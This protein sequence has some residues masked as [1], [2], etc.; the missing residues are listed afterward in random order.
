MLDARRVQA[1]QSL[2]P[3]V[4]K[5][6]QPAKNGEL[7]EGKNERQKTAHR[8]G[9]ARL[10]VVCCGSCCQYSWHKKWHIYRKTSRWAISIYTEVLCRCWISGHVCFWFEGAAWPWRWYFRE[11][12]ASSM[13][14]AS[15]AVGSW[16]YSL[17]AQSFQTSQQRLWDF[18]LI[19]CCYG[20]N[21]SYP[22]FA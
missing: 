9:C 4:W 1:T 2:I 3:R 14:K 15:L 11:N 22:H 21:L 10:F 16:T 8:S 17:L 7:T 18:P 19:C 13:G 5:R 6:W 12:Q 20:Q